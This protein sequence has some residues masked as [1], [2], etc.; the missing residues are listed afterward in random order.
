MIKIDSSYWASHVETGLYVEAAI[1]LHMLKLG[2]MWKQLLSFTCWN[3]ALCGSSC[4]ASHVETG[5]YVEAAIELH[6]LKLGF[7]WN[8]YRKQEC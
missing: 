3:W 5:L 8:I 4:W 2:F 6:M 7:M 1:E